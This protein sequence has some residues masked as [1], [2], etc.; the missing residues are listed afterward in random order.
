MG[1]ESRRPRAPPP[2]RLAAHPRLRHAAAEL[3][4]G[5]TELEELA[6]VGRVRHARGSAQ[7]KGRAPGRMHV[8]RRGKEFF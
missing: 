5:E 6:A 1:Q 3:E 7:V 4:A 2:L 8:V